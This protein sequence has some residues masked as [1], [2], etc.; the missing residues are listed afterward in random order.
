MSTEAFA[1]KLLVAYW[2]DNTKNPLV[3]YITILIIIA[4]QLGDE[5]P[6]PV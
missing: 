5:K 1:T 6:P 2:L 4:D 3:F